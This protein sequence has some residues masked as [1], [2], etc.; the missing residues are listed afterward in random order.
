MLS[1]STIFGCVLSGCTFRE[2]SL[3]LLET[4]AKLLQ[5]SLFEIS[6][7]ELLQPPACRIDSS[8]G[9]DW[10][11]GLLITEEEN[12]YNIKMQFFCQLCEKCCGLAICLLS[13]LGL[14][15]VQSP[16]GEAQSAASVMFRVTKAAQQLL[17]RVWWM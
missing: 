5:K 15:S 16:V 9:A 14:L 17:C 3:L 7:L 13:L 1:F 2:L 12:L 8:P 6:G 11:P 10:Q 4:D